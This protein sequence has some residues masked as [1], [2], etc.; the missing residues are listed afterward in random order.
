MGKIIG[1][2]RVGAT[3]HHLADQL[4]ALQG[5][6]AARIYQ[7]KAAAATGQGPQLTALLDDL[8]AGD[9]LAIT[10]LDRIARNTKHLVE[11][12][13]R[14]SER[15]VELRVLGSNLDTAT[16]DGRKMLAML[17]VLAEFERQVLLERQAEGIARAKAEGRYKGRKPTARAKA[18]EILVLDKQGL[19]RKAIAEQ[20]GI[21]VASVYRVLKDHKP[22]KRQAAAQPKSKAEVDVNRTVVKKT[23][24]KQ[25]TRV[26]DD[27]QQS[28]FD[29]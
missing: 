12:V 16:D 13:T 15:G 7:E 5:I 2:A 11:L 17:A 29:F 26:V 1:Y 21:G 4:E 8:C 22:G 10:S 27:R 18:K 14:L 28:L 19:T 6:G 25:S 24:K 3:G 23:V 9:T 20:L